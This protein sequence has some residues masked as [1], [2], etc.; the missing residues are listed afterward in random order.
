MLA[1][2][3][4]PSSRRTAK[5]PPLTCRVETIAPH[6]A[7][8]YLEKNFKNRKHSSM[9]VASYARDMKAGKWEITGD[10]I[11]FDTN[12]RLLNGQHRLL[13][14]VAA[15]TPFQTAVVYGLN[16]SAQS[17]IDTGKPRSISDVFQMH[18]VHNAMTVAAIV[19][20]IFAQK[21]GQLRSKDLKPTHTEAR[22][23]LV[24]HKGVHHSAREAQGTLGVPKAIAGYVH[25]IG[26]HVLGKEARAKAFL[27]VLKS[28]VPNYVGDPVHRFRERILRNTGVERLTRDEL[29]K[30]TIYAWNL[31]AK[32]EAVA[33]FKWPKEVWIE[34]L[35]KTDL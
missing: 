17:I 18:E 7:K 3:E 25:F 2:T 34:G 24:K 6:I 33:N 30:A 16:P 32:K 23:I 35:K 5:T 9:L 29:F 21:H 11:Q 14:C 1:V 19:R 22:D 31:F 10:P 28:G 12:G 26:F 8:A 4:R 20:T 15:D 27:E 13:A